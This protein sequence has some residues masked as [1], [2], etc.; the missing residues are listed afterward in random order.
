MSGN[1]L[2][3][4]LLPPGRLLGGPWQSEPAGIEVMMFLEEALLGIR[5][6]VRIALEKRPS[7]TQP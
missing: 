4:S 2:C 7:G 6:N 3:P 5:P 1:T